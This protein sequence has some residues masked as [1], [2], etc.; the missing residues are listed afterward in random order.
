MSWVLQLSSF[1]P[2]P[3]VSSTLLRV[4]VV[5]CRPRSL[6]L[7]ENE[8]VVRRSFRDD[9]V[10][11]QAHSRPHRSHARYVRLSA[12]SQNIGAPM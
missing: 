3:R 2:R 12:W 4:L 6:S 10:P 11:Q 9:S 5:T 8:H 7:G 1:W